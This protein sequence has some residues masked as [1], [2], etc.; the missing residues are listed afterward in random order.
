MSR[1]LWFA[2]GAGAGLWTTLKAR[3]L[4]YRLTPAGVTDQVA[5][6]ALGARIFAEEVR[7]GM[8]EREAQIAR[9]LALPIGDELGPGRGRARGPALEPQVHTGPRALAV[10]A[11]ER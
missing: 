2:A 11:A 7:L 9:E 4:A 6:W 1:A 10:P 5:T 8:T 3:R